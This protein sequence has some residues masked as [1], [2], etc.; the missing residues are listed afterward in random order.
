MHA[1]PVHF[2][3]HSLTFTSWYLEI[4]KR[5]RSL[6]LN[7]TKRWQEIDELRETVQFRRIPGFCFDQIE[8]PKEPEWP[9]VKFPFF[10]ELTDRFRVKS[11]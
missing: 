5:A 10:F 4:G 7:A 11:Q 3:R 6:M 1:D 9:D 8:I 2:V